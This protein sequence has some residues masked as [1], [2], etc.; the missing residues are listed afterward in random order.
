MAKI[1]ISQNQNQKK[2]RVHIIKPPLVNTIELRRLLFDR[3]RALV[4]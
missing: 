1:K 2:V 3:A 4:L